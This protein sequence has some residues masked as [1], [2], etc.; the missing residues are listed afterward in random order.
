MTAAA[1]NTFLQLDAIA[2]RGHASARFAVA[3][4]AGMRCLPL[5]LGDQR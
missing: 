1:A 5:A 2:T 3:Q 4:N